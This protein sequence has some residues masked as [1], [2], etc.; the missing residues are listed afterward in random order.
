MQQSRMIVLALIGSGLRYGFEM[1]EFARKSQMREWAK[2]GMSTI[3][4]VLGQLEAEG[5]VEVEIE[6][7]TKGP[8]RKAFSLTDA[9]KSRMQELVEEALASRSSV[10][11]DRIAGLIFAR[12]LPDARSREAVLHTIASLERV[13]DDLAAREKAASD[14]PVGAIVLA[15]YR[16]IYLAERKAMQAILKLESRRN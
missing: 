13:D 1:E 2:I 10:Y 9:G 3:Y 12:L 6:E 11:S 16:D 7:S 8:N 4:K 14:D 5:A 15:Y